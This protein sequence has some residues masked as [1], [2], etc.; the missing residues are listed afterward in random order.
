VASQGGHQGQKED[1]NET[2][3]GIGK[4]E[5]SEFHDVLLVRMVR[6]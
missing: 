3:G 2:R 5:S 4:A 1:T 6:E